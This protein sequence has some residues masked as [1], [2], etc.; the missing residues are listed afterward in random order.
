MS[1]PGVETPGTLVRG[2]APG[3]AIVVTLG[4]ML[5]AGVFGAVAPAAAVAGGGLLISLCVAGAIASCN[6]TSAARLGARYPLAGGTYVYAGRRLGPMAGFAAGWCFLVGK[7]ASCAAMALV[8]GA[9]LWPAHART[10][11]VGATL[12][13]AALNHRGIHTTV[14]VTL[15]I[16]VVVLVG[17]AVAVAG[18]L[19]AGTGGLG[20][21]SGVT[22]AGL[23]NTLQAAG[24]LFFAFAGYARL[25][26][27]GAEV[28]DP[29]RTI[30]WATAW[31]MGIALAIYLAVMTAALGAVGPAAL[32]S[33]SHPL[34]TAV[35]A[36]GLHALA[37][38]VAVAAVVASIGVLLSLMAAVART[39]YAMAANHDLPRALAAVHPEFRV[40]HTAGVVVALLV[41]LGAGLLD[42]R[43]SIA[44]SGALV[45]TYYA[46]TNLSAL[47]LRGGSAVAD[48]AAVVGLVGCI[49][50]ALSL[51]L[52][53]VL[54]AGGVL[55]LGLAGRAW[56][57][58][59][60]AP[61]RRPV[62]GP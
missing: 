50:V 46:L 62:T 4:A 35:R 43:Q 5:G 12:L 39:A 30:P 56:V 15:A 42:L 36:G 6:A 47:R 8:A 32:A 14:R 54:A 16:V 27:F 49:V 9:Y 26:A 21:W 60:P 55:L 1:L 38:V 2:I 10:A 20:G 53:G 3:A 22:G 25:T 18:S 45:L 57:P 40:P 28:R 44:L 59:P 7:L 24:L 17:L 37:P 13:C 11:A 23:G 48:I 58:R 51:P 41:A 29:R 34:V 31:S 19:D 61:R 33:S 52:P